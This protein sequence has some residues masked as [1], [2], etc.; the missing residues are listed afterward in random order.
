MPQRLKDVTFT[1]ELETVPMGI[2]ALAEKGFKITRGTHLRIDIHCT[3]PTCAGTVTFVVPALPLEEREIPDSA[4]CNECGTMV[5][6]K[7]DI[8]R[9]ADPTEVVLPPAR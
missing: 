9:H 2:K 7:E 1:G 8:L 3:I 5:L 4:P 6:L